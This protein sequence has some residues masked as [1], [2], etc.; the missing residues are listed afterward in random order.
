MTVAGPHTIRSV[1]AGDGFGLALLS[2]GTVKAWGE[3]EYGQL[4]DGTE[5]SRPIPGSVAGLR[6][7]KTI[8][9]GGTFSLALLKDGTLRSWGLN[10][11]GQLADGTTSNRSLPVQ[12]KG[13]PGRV[14]AIAA[15]GNSALALLANGT[16]YAWGGNVDGQLGQGGADSRPHPV[17]LAVRL[18]Q[19]ATSI[20]SGLFHNL[21]VLADGSVRGWGLNIAGQVGNGN[22]ISPQPNPVAVVGL[23]GVRV[24]SVDGGFGHTLALLTNGRMKA[25]GS[26]GSGQ[27]GDGTNTLRLIPVNVLGLS[28]VSAIAA[29]YDGSSNSGHSLAITHGDVMSWGSNQW[30][31]LGVGGHQSSNRALPVTTGLHPTRSISGG[32]AFSLAS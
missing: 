30:G 15:G 9:A 2:N 27:L 7:V 6:D 10:S 25:W 29:G 11:L 17:P 16:V 1:S 21:A 32:F 8:A 14:T 18:P 13:L 28:G 22:T 26:N 24:K 20:G 12:V 4:G 23:N 19:R 5:I 3:N 31:Q